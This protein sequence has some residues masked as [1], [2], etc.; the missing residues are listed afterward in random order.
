[1]SRIFLSHSSRDSFEALA[2]RQWLVGEGWSAEDIFIDLH[3]IGAG[4]RWREALLRANERCEAVVLL[5]SPAALDSMECR[6]EVRVAEDLGKEIIVTIVYGLTVDDERLSPYHERQIVDLSAEPR[7]ITIS[8]EHQDTRK[9]IHFSAPALDQVKS[10]LDQLGIS[11]NT[12]SWRPGKLETASPYPGLSG[13]DEGDAGL[14]FGRGGDIARG[15]ADIRRVRRSTM[16]RVLVIQAASGAGKSSFLRA[17]LWPRLRRDP[18]FTPI[19]ILRPATGILRGD[20]GLSRGLAEWFALQRRPGM[21]ARAIQNSLLKPENEAVQN[22]AHFLNE[23]IALAHEVRKVAMPDAP[24]PAPVLAVDQAEELFADANKQESKQFL[25]LLSALLRPTTE[26]EANHLRPSSPLIVLLTIRADSVD[27]LLHA[28]TDIGLPAPQPFLLPPLAREAYRDI[29]L[30]PAEVA[31]AAGLRLFIEEELAAALVRD[32][33]GADALPLL[34]FTLKQLLADYRSGAEAQLTLGQYQESGGVGGALAQRLQA[35]QR[36]AG[37]DDPDSD[38]LKRLFIPI[39][40]TWDD[41]ATPP[42]AKRLVAREA[43]LFSG[44]RAGLRGLA[45]ALVEERLLTRSGSDGGPTLEVAHE[46]LLRQPPLSKWLEESEDFLI[47]RKRLARAREAFDANERGLLTSREL[48]V[49]RVWV[50][51]KADDEIPAKDRAFIAQSEAEDDRKRTEDNERERQRQAA[52]LE[53]AKARAEIA[54]RDGARQAAE[55][56]A[57]RAREQASKEVAEAARE[58]EQAV[59]KTAEAAQVREQAARAMS[60]VSRRIARRT[61][62]GLAGAIVFALIAFA[63]GIYAFSQQKQAI[64]GQNEALIARNEALSSRNDAVAAR[65]EALASR[66]EAITVR[67]EAISARND[68]FINQSRF[69]SDHSLRESNGNDPITGALLALEALPDAGSDDINVK[70]RPP[71]PLAAVSLESALRAARERAIIKGHEGAVQSVAVTPDG[72]RIVSG[73]DDKTIRIWDAKTFTE[74]AQLKGHKDSVQSVAVTP[75]GARIVSGSSDNTVRIWDAKTFKELAQLKGHEDW[76]QS[77]AITPDGT[78]IV[79]GSDDKIIRIWDATNFTELAQL[80]GQSYVQSVAV[81][82]DGTRIVTGADDKT[83]RIWDAKTFTELAQLKGHEGS[84]RSVA[85]TPD[86]SRIVSGSSDKTIRIWDAKTFTELAQLKGHENGVQSVAVT[87]DGARIVSG[88]D[89][90]TIRI[91]DAKTFTELAQ[92]KGHEGSV[93]SVAVTPDGTSIIS[94]STDSTARIWRLFPTG[95]A[96]VDRAK[97]LVPRCLTPAQRQLVYL[98]PTPPRWCVTLAKCPYDFGSSVIEGD[99]LVDAGEDDEAKVLFA[100]AVA[101]DSAAARRIDG[102]WA[103]AYIHRAERLLFDK[104]K[105]EALTLFDAAI[106]LNPKDEAAYNGRGRT[107]YQ[108]KAYDDAVADFDQAIQLDPKKSRILCLSGLCLLR[109]EGLRPRRHEN[110]SGNP[111]R[112]KKRRILCHSGLCLSRKEGLRP[113]R[114]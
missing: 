92:L 28:T 112:S 71:W 4:A 85:V 76:V 31:R 45:D 9:T 69:L 7:T 113:R 58:R 18:D 2:F 12:F 13:F 1:M 34:A 104:K 91:W 44:E 11:P 73:S 60:D 29:I 40:T 106:Q 83:I 59:L 56:E 75:D 55:L 82:P 93:R 37:F 41:E 90:K 17:G 57:A 5:A 46:A 77:V 47:W 66:N 102:I 81:T 89:D 70:G 30:K 35:A 105:D 99:R 36:E 63:I 25:R 64:A 79:S 54:E 15:L 14:F 108:A 114:H 32:S 80:K 10:R 38:A 94:A 20:S 21:T 49:A 97:T 111:T 26:G 50:V 42:G 78:R 39:L 101:H 107:Y 6:I 87:P 84:V 100:E 16:S 24:P 8:V 3:G 74:L 27:A 72:S 67:N 110:W 61:F 23:G 43:E 19:S 98:A 86:G 22:L 88:S 109:K 96:L 52:E 65:N 33:D 103:R 68:A 62:A 48:Q 51:A 95:Q 53:A